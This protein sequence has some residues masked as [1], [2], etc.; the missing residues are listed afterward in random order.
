MKK[1]E[2]AIIIDEVQG[3]FK[4]ARVA[5]LTD[6]RG[7]NVDRITDLRVKLRSVK[8]E[9][10]VVKNTLA[11]KAAN[12]TSVEKLKDYFNGPVGIVL[13]Y[14]DSLSVLKVLTE[15]AKKEENLKIKA[16]IVEDRLADLKEIKI[17]ADLPAKD[18][19]LSKLLMGMKSPIYGL[20]GSVSGILQKLVF[21]LNSVKDL[22]A[23]A[24]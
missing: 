20:A 12:G 14:D 5:V 16:G 4:R 3:K 24:G 22:K 18:V 17:L 10:K 7:L 11:N 1:A 15:F 21:A 6:Y 9:Y 13:S 2:K 8:G 19:L 23:K